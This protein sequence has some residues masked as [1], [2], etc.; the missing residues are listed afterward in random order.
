MKLEE[1]VFDYLISYYF[2]QFRLLY[3]FFVCESMSLVT[4]AVL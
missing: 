3:C 2:I 1:E 4:I